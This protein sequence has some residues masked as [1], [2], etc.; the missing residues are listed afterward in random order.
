MDVVKINIYGKTAFFKKPEVNTYRYLTYGQ[1]HKVALMGIFGCILG[2][3][4]YGQ[5][6][7]KVYP[8]FYEKL[9]DIKV[10]IVPISPAK[11][12]GFSKKIQQFNNSVGYASKEEGGNLIVTEQWLENVSWEVYILCNNDISNKLK[13]ALLGKNTVYIPY[14]GK[15]DHVANISS[16]EVYKGVETQDVSYISTLDSLFL[17]DCVNIKKL[18]KPNGFRPVKAAPSCGLEKMREYVYQEFLPY[19]LEP[20]FNTYDT[21]KFICTNK[22]I[23]VNDKESIIYSINDKN[24]FF[25]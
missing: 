20:K 10:S 25:Y 11:T 6:G 12:G 9:K 5:Q 23:E 16:I 4:G 21:R 24:L 18:I 8:E 3:N 7:D 19:A 15:N 17:K 1:L 13:D 14:L 2:L 22:S